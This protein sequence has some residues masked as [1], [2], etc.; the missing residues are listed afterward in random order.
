MIL[1]TLGV[2]PQ[3]PQ[4]TRVEGKG[5]LIQDQHLPQ[6]TVGLSILVVYLFPAKLPLQ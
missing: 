1:D 4:R 3:S 5:P 2:Q 6:M